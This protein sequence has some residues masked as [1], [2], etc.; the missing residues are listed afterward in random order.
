[1]SAKLTPDALPLQRIYFWEKTQ[2]GRVAFT[3][4]VGGGQ[5]RDYTWGEAV[6][7]ARRMA[8]HRCV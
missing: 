5:V 2:A 3:Q 7:Q 8:A 6:D 4:P 1:M